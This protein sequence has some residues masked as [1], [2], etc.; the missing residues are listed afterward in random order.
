MARCVPTLAPYFL[1]CAPVFRHAG[2]A[3]ATFAWVFVGHFLFLSIFMVKNPIPPTLFRFDFPLFSTV[4]WNEDRL[5]INAGSL[6]KLAINTIYSVRLG[7]AQDVT[8]LAFSNVKR[9]K[10]YFLRPSVARNRIRAGH[11][12]FTVGSGA[13]A[14]HQMPIMKV[15]GPSG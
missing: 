7:G 4:R 12:K 14:C 1:D 13:F 8:I 6:A 10:P 9:A 5:G 3:F 15:P 11:E 2:T